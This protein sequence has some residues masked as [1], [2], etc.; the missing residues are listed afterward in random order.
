MGKTKVELVA[1]R[2]NPE[3]PPRAWG[4][5]LIVAFRGGDSGNTPTSV[6]KTTGQAQNQDRA[7]KHPHER[8]EDSTCHPA[9]RHCYRNTPTSVGK[10]PCCSLVII[11]TTETPPRA[12]GRRRNMG[13][14]GR[15]FGNTPTSV[16]KTPRNKSVRG[17]VLE[18]P[19]RAWGRHTALTGATAAVGNTPTSVGKTDPALFLRCRQGETPPRAWGRQAGGGFTR[20]SH[21]NTPTSVGKTF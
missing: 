16:G 9:W 10:T 4:R 14:V 8:G 12:W 19:P 20:G 7:G 1:K 2:V 3:T 6:G 11:A 18:T 15:H 17:F 21:R 13:F 5:H